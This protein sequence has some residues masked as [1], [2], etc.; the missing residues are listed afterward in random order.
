MKTRIELYRKDLIIVGGGVTGCVAAIAAARLGVKT[1]LIHNRPVLGGPSSSECCANSDGSFICG[2]SE[3]VNAESR[4]GGILDELKTEAKYRKG[5]GYDE[6]WSLLL[7]EWVERED[8]IKLFLNTEAYE[9]K[10]SG[11]KIK[12]VIARTI[13][14]QRTFR[15]EAP[16]FIDCSGD[17]ILGFSAGA[18]FRCGREGKSEFNES[19]A[20]EK[21]DSKTMG[22]SIAFRAIDVGHPV[23][24]QPPPWAMKFLTDEDFPYRSHLNPRK[25][26]WW[27]EYG[28]ELDTIRDNDEIYRKLLSI[29]FGVWDH[30]KNHGDHG[31]DN[32]VIN[33]ISSI[34]AKRESRRLT[35]DYV[36][37]QNDVTGHNDFPDAVAYGGWPIDLH[38]P[39]GFFSKGHPG[40]PPPFVFPGVYQIPFR[41]LFSKNVNNLMMAG[42]NISVTHVALGSTRVMA[43]CALT[44]QAAGT[45]AFLAKKHHVSPREISQKH[46]DELKTLLYR[47]DAGELGSKHVISGN[48]SGRAKV[49]A[50]SIMLLG[51]TGPST[52][53]VPLLAPPRNP[54]FYDP[55]NEPPAD[56]RRAQMF[57]VSGDYLDSITLFFN[58]SNTDSVEVE[59]SLHEALGFN[60]FD[61]TPAVKSLKKTLSTGKNIAVSFNVCITAIPGKLYYFMLSPVPGVD[62]H[63]S[64]RY[65][66]G[67]YMKP[68]G[69][70]LKNETMA[71]KIVPPQ[72]IFAPPNVVNGLTRGGDW[73][74]AWISNPAN[75]LPQ[76]LTLEFAGPEPVN[77]VEL[78]FDTNLRVA[79]KEGVAPECVRDYR[80]SALVDGLWL[81][82]ADVYDNYFRRRRHEFPPVNATA[83]RLTVTAT[84]GDVSARVHEF[85]A[86]KP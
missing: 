32:Y 10:M 16:L 84:N 50:D 28:G 3:Y 77:A 2:A 34:P 71:F 61:H 81:K 79:V 47:E 18:E 11:K 67:L 12:S 65:I 80:I 51:E 8:N 7:R 1:A 44:G 35:G 73:P 45:A 41:C 26:Y 4:E 29:L 49:S 22:S 13:E 78:I 36:M 52:D 39:E 17:S 82:I 59:F 56:R 33:W 63:I 60:N 15:F 53:A 30:V 37:T 55:C 83:L 31:A 20:P 42:R 38:P 14:S 21:P 9:V 48:I 43:T 69:C 27:L 58:N 24:F 25:G 66:P 68:D 75:P 62:V 85:R 40:S 54:S 46:I 86:F 64:N 70:Y 76:N 19:L 23:K 74:N 5:V 6:H 57:P 72:N